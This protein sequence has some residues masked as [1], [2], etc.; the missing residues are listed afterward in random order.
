LAGL[1]PKYEGQLSNAIIIQ[2]NASEIRTANVM[3]W[4]HL[5][6]LI[7]EGKQFKNVKA[8]TARVTEVFQ[9][10]KGAIPGVSTLLGLC[11]QFETLLG[12]ALVV[13][14]GFRV[15]KVDKEMTE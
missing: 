14:L 3:K 8:S 6:E 2:G 9:A 10:E 13:R 15:A 12:N 4:R 11:P 7:V 1:T 5:G